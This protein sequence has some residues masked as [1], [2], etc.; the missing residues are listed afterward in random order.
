MLGHP[1]QTR[2]PS[3]P[4]AHGTQICGIELRKCYFFSFTFLSF[5]LSVVVHSFIRSLHMCE[6][7]LCTRSWGEACPVE[8]NA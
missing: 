3:L 1:Q 4:A 5:C 6:C 7:L 8:A 2:V